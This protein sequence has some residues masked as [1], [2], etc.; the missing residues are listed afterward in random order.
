MPQDRYIGRKLWGMHRMP[1]DCGG[2]QPEKKF[3]VETRFRPTAPTYV[4]RVGAA[5]ASYLRENSNI[6]SGEAVYL[7]ATMDEFR[8]LSLAL[9][10]LTPPF[11]SR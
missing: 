7:E 1:M 3:D 8:D 9:A 5:G 11:S 2:C 4:G 10:L 6:Q